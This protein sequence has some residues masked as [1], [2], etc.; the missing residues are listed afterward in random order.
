MCVLLAHV[1]DVTFDLTPEVYIAIFRPTY[2]I[3]KVGWKWGTEMELFIFV[4]FHF[5]YAPTSH[6][7]HKSD[8]TIVS[9]D[10]ND[11]L[12]EEVYACYFSTTRK[13]AVTIFN[14][15]CSFKF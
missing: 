2:D 12:V 11:I 8:S 1:D 7:I 9:G 13:L 6:Y 3:I 10:H 15:N 4:T 14:I 5:H